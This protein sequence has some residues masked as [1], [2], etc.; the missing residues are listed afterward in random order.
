MTS[1]IDST[2][3]RLFSITLELVH[4]PPMVNLVKCSYVYLEQSSFKVAM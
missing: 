1:L 4:D 3:I 2:N